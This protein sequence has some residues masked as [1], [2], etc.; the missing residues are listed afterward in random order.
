MTNTTNEATKQARWK[1][2]LDLFE[3]ALPLEAAKREALLHASADPVLTRTVKELLSA[4]LDSNT[5][6]LL[7]TPAWFYTPSA[8]NS[9]TLVGQQIGAYRLTQFLAAGGMGE[10]YLAERADQM[11]QRVAALKL[12]SAALDKTQYRRFCREVQIL[13]DLKHPNLVLL[14]D[15]GRAPDGR[16]YLVMEYVAGTD[17]RA[18][19]ELHGAMPP[20][21]LVEVLRQACAGLHAAHAGGIIHRDIK[22]ANLM[23]MEERGALT[24]EVLDFGIAARPGAAE[25]VS[26]LTQGP[27]GTLLYM[28]PEQLRGDK[29]TPAADVYALG[30]TAY[31]LLT[32][33]PPITG[34]SPA[35]IVTKHLHQQPAPP[36]ARRADLNIPR[37]VDRVLLKALAKEPAQRYQNAPEFAAALAA[38]FNGQSQS[39]W[40]R[41]LWLA[42]ALL[43]IVGVAVY[44]FWSRTPPPNPTSQATPTP[45]VTAASP[46]SIRP[47]DL[48][49]LLTV[50][51]LARQPLPGSQ[52]ELFKAGLSAIPPT[53]TT[54]NTLC[55]QTTDANG[56]TN[57]GALRVSPGDYFIR[58]RRAGYKNF[59]GKTTLAADPKAPGTV[60]L[61]V[62]L[63]PQ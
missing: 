24:V 61:R 28:S 46:T 57:C 36:S 10:V 18:W 55:T 21:Q 42:A 31:E 1:R 17:L 15:A 11:F 48:Q 3:E 37:A 41:R 12:I 43:S 53:A 26:S 60:R 22:P 19:L 59:E 6:D 30:L 34:N 5:E 29:L 13:A 51:N 54:D 27:L 62:R 40:L 47:A 45:V 9:R 63:E 49:V 58:V 50:Q 7:E 2:A 8:G 56:A 20:T 44:W 35:E 14:Y 16:P 33:H 4:H 25:S 52:V 32:G 39:D 23:L 38:A